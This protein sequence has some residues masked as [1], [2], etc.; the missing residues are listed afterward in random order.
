[1]KRTAAGGFWASMSVGLPDLT[2]GE[3]SN[4]VIPKVEEPLDIPEG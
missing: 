1:M 3:S 4:S 2:F